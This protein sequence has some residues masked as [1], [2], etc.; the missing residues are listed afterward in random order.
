MVIAGLV[1]M[2]I[3]S[4]FNTQGSFISVIFFGVFYVLMG[5][6]YFFPSLYLFRYASSIGSLLDGGGAREMEKALSNQKSFWKFAGILTLVSFG[7]AIF[8]IIAALVIP[9]FAKI[10]GH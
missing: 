2:F 1:N 6:L 3:F 7:F 4:K 8:G 9:Q 10:A 5:L